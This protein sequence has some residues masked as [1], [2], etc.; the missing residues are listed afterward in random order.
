[1]PSPRFA[2]VPDPSQSPVP[3]PCISVCKM[4]PVTGWCEGCHRTI[5]EIA[6]WSRMSDD[7]RRLVWTELARRRQQK[8]A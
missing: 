5:D 4:S 8:A 1:M 6:G 7:A 2:A 3:S